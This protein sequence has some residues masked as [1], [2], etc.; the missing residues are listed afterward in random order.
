M[1]LSILGG[2]LKGLRLAAPVESITRPTAVMLRRKIFDA[3][4]DLSG[5]TFVDLFAGS[6]A[7]GI[8][9]YSRHAEDVYFS[10]V[11]K[12]AFK[13]LCQ[14]LKKVES[15]LDRK[16]YLGKASKWLELNI[17]RVL[18]K[19]SVILFIDPPYKD[20]YLVEEIID[21]LDGQKNLGNLQ[22]WIESD[23]QKGFSEAQLI[24]ILELRKWEVA[25]TY[26]QGQH[27]IIIANIQ[28]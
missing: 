8:E 9:A 24:K 1:S 4:Q 10:E 26:K 28:S 16:P 2:R 17:E 23:Q 27:Y 13:V 21:F 5:L 19:S 20:T 22:L 12:K 6:G 15:G 11:S 3:H 25:R 14:N 18:E 7:V